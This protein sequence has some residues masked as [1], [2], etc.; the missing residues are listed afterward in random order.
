MGFEKPSKVEGLC[1]VFPHC[2]FAID[3]NACL[4]A[5]LGLMP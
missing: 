5:L 2:L 3:E 4:A 1:R